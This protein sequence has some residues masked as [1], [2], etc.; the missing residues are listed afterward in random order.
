MR[1]VPDVIAVLRDV[2]VIVLAL[3]AI[4]LFLVP[5]WLLYTITRALTSA[6]PR[7]SPAMQ[8]LRHDLLRVFELIDG[9]MATI[10][11]AF[12]WLSATSARMRSLYAE[13]E[14]AFRIGR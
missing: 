8:K 12:I 13:C 14:R 6:L 11:A 9:A 3:Q 7:V 1:M 10:R 2:A 4:A 5:L